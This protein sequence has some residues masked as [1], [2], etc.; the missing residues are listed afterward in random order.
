MDMMF[1]AKKL[2]HHLL[3]AEMIQQGTPPS[4]HCDDQLLVSGEHS[5]AQSETNQID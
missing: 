2:S 3:H 1:S 5:E 4:K